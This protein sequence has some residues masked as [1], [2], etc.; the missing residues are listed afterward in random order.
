M[1]KHWLQTIAICLLFTS[2]ATAGFSQKNDINRTP[3]Q[4]GVDIQRPKL[5]V[6]LMVDQMRWDFLYRYQERFGENG[7]KRLLREGF[8]CENT[9]IPYAQTVTAPGHASVYSGTTPAI[10]G[11]MG[12][13]WYDKKLGRTVYCVED[14]TVKPVGGNPKAEPMSPRNLKVT[15][16]GDQINLAFNYRS[17]VVGIAIKDRGSILPAGHSGDAYWYDSRSGE[18]MTS[19]HYY[20]QLPSWVNSFNQRKIVDSLYNLDWNTLYPIETYVQSDRDNVAYEGR[21]GH[22]KE[23]VFPHILKNLMGANFGTIRA[24]PYGNTMTLAFA[25]AALE[26]ENLGQDNITDLLA[27]SLSSQ[28][29]IGHQFGPNSIETEDTYLRLDR[30]LAA[31]F[32][33][34]DEKVGS[35]QWTFFLTADHGVAHVPGFLAKHKV[36][37]STI[38][39]NTAALTQLI[40][41]KYKVPK[42]ISAFSNYHLY[43]NDEA[44]DSVGANKEAIIKTMLQELNKDTAVWLAFEAKALNETPMPAEVKERFAKGMNPELSGDIIVILK[45]GYFGGGRSGTTHGSWYP[46]DAHIPLV[47]MGWGIRP[48][49]T[50]KPTWMIDIAPTIAALLHIQPPSGTLGNPIPEITDLH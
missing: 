21:F 8:S 15:S 7:F 1:N 16:L 42:V 11:I 40:Q 33:F 48:G 20:D 28:D 49:Y 12:N 47:F 32:S 34:L 14:E 30:D 41:K 19:T 22:E 26:A 2:F 13:E 50:F 5:V 23:P 31:F 6:G 36:P 43:L 10:H 44:I 9:Q 39:L 27:V 25:K 29:Y 35:G 18:F 37:V 46:Y 24:T 4:A 45:S 3:I 17:K 38:N